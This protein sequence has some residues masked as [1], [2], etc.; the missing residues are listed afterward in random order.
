MVK[1]SFFV[2]IQRVVSNDTFCMSYVTGISHTK[3]SATY[4]SETAKF[5]PQSEL[6][7]GTYSDLI[8]ILI[9]AERSHRN[10]VQTGR[11][12]HHGTDVPA[13]SPSPSVKA[14]HART[15]HHHNL[16]TASRALGVWQ[17]NRDP[18]LV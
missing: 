1:I 9:P 13:P 3:R 12:N 16:Q 15:Q 14:Q 17:I 6:A 7:I 11:G 18:R 8:A 4:R 2:T 10:T 5:N